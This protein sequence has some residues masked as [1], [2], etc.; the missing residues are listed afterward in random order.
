[1]AVKDGE[2]GA[3]VRRLNVGVEYRYFSHK[4]NFSLLEFCPGTGQR[5]GEIFI[6]K[7]IDVDDGGVVMKKKNR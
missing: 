7:K 2:E 4:L 5:E 3:S 6:L 1:M